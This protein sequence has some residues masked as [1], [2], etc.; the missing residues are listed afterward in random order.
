MTYKEK[1]NS[2]IVKYYNIYNILLTMYIIDI[3]NVFCFEVL[4]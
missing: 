4:G 2:L 3:S 1:F